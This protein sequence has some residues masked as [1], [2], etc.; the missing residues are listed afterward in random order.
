MGRRSLLLGDGVLRGADERHP[1]AAVGCEAHTI[2]E[3]SQPLG[4][5]VNRPCLRR[6]HPSGMDYSTG[7]RQTISSTTKQRTKNYE[8]TTSCFKEGLGI[9]TSTVR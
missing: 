9:E 5:R 3:T 8:L 7:S 1:E 4:H 2:G 6:I